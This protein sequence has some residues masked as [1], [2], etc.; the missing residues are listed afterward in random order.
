MALSAA[1]FIS[2]VEVLI[3]LS[4]QDIDTSIGRYLNIC[5]IELWNAR[6]WRER[7]KEVIVTTVAPY[8]TGT[9]AISNGS[10]AL[11]GTGTTFTTAMTGRK[12]CIGT[13]GPIYRVTYVSPTA[14]T[15][16]RNYQESAQTASS[17][18]I[19]QDEYDV[20]TD[21][22]VMRSVNLNLSTYRGPL[23]EITEALMDERSYATA[24]VTVPQAWAPT[25]D[26]TA[27]SYRMRLWP[28]PDGVY[29]LRV[30]YQK[31][32]TD[33]ATTDV[34]PF[35]PSMDRLILLKTTLMAQMIPGSRQSITEQMVESLTE[36]IWR[37]QQS[38][39]PLMVS[40]DGF[41]VGLVSWATGQIDVA[42]L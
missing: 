32:W 7:K 4:G 17:F 29:A 8:T 26:T 41:D 36:K 13:G 12:F 15:L 5:G 40:R 37:E 18:T 3:E 24:A 38:E 2:E 6:Q 27:G 16:S 34:S 10:T 20:A 21:V 39:Q 22:D 30:L 31:S 25:V 33:I 42:S 9:I 35:G 11:V 28:I 14:M 19:Y 1:Q 23:A